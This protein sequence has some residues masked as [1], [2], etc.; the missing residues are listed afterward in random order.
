[1]SITVHWY[2]VPNGA[3]A[4]AAER[5]DDKTPV[6][7]G[8]EHKLARLTPSGEE[9]AVLHKFHLPGVGECLAEFAGVEIS[10][11]SGGPG[12]ME[13]LDQELLSV[14]RTIAFTGHASKVHA[15]PAESQE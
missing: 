8:E 9:I 4:V 2:L 3:P 6:H 11:R 12:E 10:V 14:R 5:Q 13:R 15:S 1:M 7:S